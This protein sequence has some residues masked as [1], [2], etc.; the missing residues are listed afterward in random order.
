M[1][2]Y[3]AAYGKSRYL[4]IVSAELDLTKRNAII[5]ESPRGEE[6][7]FIV[8][9]INEQQETLY[10]KMRNTADHAEGT[11]KATEPIVC[12]LSFI[13]AAKDCDLENIK[14]YRAEEGEVLRICK[15]L[16]AP[17]K[18]DMKLID[19]EFLHDKKKLF[20]Y[21]SSDI[22]VDFRAYV[23]DLA[24][25]FKTRIELRQI[26]ARDEAKIVRGVGPC[27]RPCCCTY[28]L[29]QFA[30]ICIKMV[31]EQNLALNP[32]KISGICGRLMCCMCF[33]HEA[34]KEAWEGF[35][36]S[37]SKIKTPEGSI[38]VSG[39]DLASASLRCMVAGKGEIKVPKDKFEEFKEVVSNGGE[40]MPPEEDIDESP[41]KIH[42]SFQSILQRTELKESADKRRPEKH[43]SQHDNE[44][45][46]A[47]GSNNAKKK[48]KQR[49][50]KREEEYAYD[51]DLLI[52]DG[53]PNIKQIVALKQKEEAIEDLQNSKKKAQ[54][55]KRSQLK[56]GSGGGVHKK[57]EV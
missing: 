10:R 35:P 33:E 12:D 30:P 28:W 19:V 57:A 25:E 47:D 5:A 53:M 26:G 16:L 2:K 55:H 22:R 42:D 24:R 1:K 18:L 20:I 29:N 8:G 9:R 49:L 44:S 36:A 6:V 39:I 17:H 23:R 56:K 11:G 21:F 37:G 45:D 7:A 40:W 14:N 51:D 50:P 52:G 27:G 43:L 15:V 54:K 13:A 4:G 31:K 41:F 46:D 3:L 34:Y 38:V 48:K 32:A